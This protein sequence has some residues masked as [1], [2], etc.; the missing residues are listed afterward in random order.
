MQTSIVSRRPLV[1]ARSLGLF[2]A[3][4]IGAL[5]AATGVG[6]A[7]ESE[8][9]G[10]ASSPV[11]SG[12][13]DATST[14]VVAID[15]LLPTGEELCTGYLI[16]PDLV[17]TARHCVAPVINPG[18]ACTAT[19]M[20]PAALGGTPIAPS[21]LGVYMETTLTAA[22][23]KIDVAEITVLPGS[24]GAPLCG[25]DI[26]LLRLAAPIADVPPLP[27]KVSTPPAVGDSFT[28]IGYGIMNPNAAVDDSGTR[29]SRSGL[30]VSTV[31]A[32]TRTLDGEWIADTG[33]CA[34]DSGSPAI[35][36]D[37]KAFGVMSRGPKA[38]CVG[39]IYQ[40]IDVHADFLVAAAQASSMRLGIA[41][42]VWAGG[43][44][45]TGGAGGGATT[46]AGGGG[47]GGASVNP[48]NDSGCAVN[49]GESS[50]ASSL[51][52]AAALLGSAALRRARSRR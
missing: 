14:A 3:L 45:G 52:F 2:G 38:T 19:P 51:F 6:C 9:T 27:L 18:A 10:R 20:Y 26:A 37:G 4:G 25:S 41:A 5:L 22:S 21:K 31:G 7:V 50:S 48:K 15:T 33:P 30:T 8:P 13:T 23:K 11:L 16:M 32:T 42:P 49:R 1:P 35:D 40:R 39:M 28:A 24:E 34:G 29:R 46:G 43:P 44:A 47:T 12:E 17:L 36:A